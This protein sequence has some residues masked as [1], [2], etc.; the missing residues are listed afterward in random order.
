MG[1]SKEPDFIERQNEAAT[2]KK[3]ALEKF[4]ASAADPASGQR[5]RAR[6]ASA[7]ERAAAK[8]TREIEET[9]RKARDAELATE[10]KRTTP[11]RLNVLW[12][13]KLNANAR[14]RLAA[15]QRGTLGTLP[16]KRDRKRAG[17]S[18][19]ITPCGMLLLSS[20]T[21]PN[22]GPCR[23][24]G[25]MSII[26]DLAKCG[27]CCRCEAARGLLSRWRNGPGMRSA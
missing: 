24:A 22:S 25:A 7:T 18:S 4:R 13:R 16:E 3:A 10:A 26:Q 1:R 5:L 11:F 23:R 8:R 6:A 19:K 21:A 12:P 17:D 20:G 15:R 9:K 14:Y 2:A 27:E